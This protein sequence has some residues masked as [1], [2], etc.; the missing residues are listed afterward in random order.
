RRTQRGGR[1]APRRDL[2]GGTEPPPLPEADA[3]GAAPRPPW[4]S[5]PPGAGR[6]WSPEA[7]GPAP[8]PGGQ[9]PTPPWAGGE[10][11]APPPAP[12]RGPAGGAAP[13]PAG[14]PPPAPGSGGGAA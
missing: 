4:L 7:R 10:Q 1:S 5:E 3:A 14:G 6:S 9:R 2:P 11:H 13:P 12:P 8:R